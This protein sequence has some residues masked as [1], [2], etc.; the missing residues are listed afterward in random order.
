MMKDEK[1]FEQCADLG[2]RILINCRNE[3]YQKYPYLDGAFTSL[4]YKTVEKGSIGTD[5]EYLYFEPTYLIQMYAKDPGRVRR[6]YL[7]ILL[8]C[9]YLHIVGMKNDTEQNVVNDDATENAYWNL[10]CDMAVE[11]TIDGNGISAEKNYGILK[12]ETI[13]PDLTEEYYFDD[14]RFWKGCEQ[15]EKA[16]RIRKKWEQIASYTSKNQKNGQQNRG[17]RYGTETRELEVIQKGKYDY[18][19]FLKKFTVLREE[20]ELDM[21]SFDYGFYHYGM[22]HYGNLPLIEPLEYK[23]VNRLEELVIAIDTSG[24]CSVE[25]VQRFLEETYRIF[26]EK[27]NFFRKMNVYLV[28]CDC[29]I[30][31]VKVIH[32][33]E[34]WME[35]SK[36]IVIRGRAGT[37]FRPVFRY[38]EEKRR[39]KEIKNLKA[40]IYFTDG[41]GVF[42]E[43]TEYETA[44][45]FV[46]KCEG[47]K[48]VPEWAEKLLIE[49]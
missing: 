38:V 9:L 7:H 34:E 37:D 49:P 20:V 3:L 14:H 41:D 18:R 13:E 21:E 31:E 43:K 22:G 39:K 29:C 1:N 15:G 47:M 46:K 44:F 25:T 35:Y 26:S 32:S 30:Q 23:E 28:Q 11:Q 8:H 45:V 19:R 42:P 4:T 6:G 10:A 40:L 48:L 17:S 12:R 16:S 2:I 27:E 36:N 33:E 5:G 24:S